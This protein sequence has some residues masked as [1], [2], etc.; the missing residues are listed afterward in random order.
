M[1]NVIQISSA[2]AMAS[3]IAVAAFAVAG[4]AK[5][6]DRIDQVI[7]AKSDELIEVRRDIHRHPEVAG[8]E[9]RTAG[10]IAKRLQSLGLEVRTDVGGHGVIGILKGGKPGPVVAYRADM[11]AL[12]S[13]DPDPVD[14]PSVY[15]GVRHVCGHDM[16]TTV[17]L[18]IA[19]ALSSVREDLGGTVKFI[20][21]PAEETATGAKAMIKDGALIDPVPD[22]IFAV[23]CA[24]LPTGQFGSQV[25]MMLPGLDYVQ[26]ALSGDGDLGAAAEM[27]SAVVNGMNTTGGMAPQAS[28]N[29]EALNAALVPGSFISSGVFSSVAE[30][31]GWSIAGMV[32]ASS[33]A[34]HAHAKQG[35]EEGLLALDLVGVAYKLN[36]TER[37]IPAVNNDADLVRAAE[38]V[39]RKLGGD[40]AVLVLEETTPFFSEDF[41]HFQQDVPGVMFFLGVANEA[42]GTMALPHHPMFVAD[43]AAIAVGVRTMSMVMVDFLSHRP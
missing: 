1:A 38:K 20:F 6:I 28:V 16:H 43:E 7:A 4:P 23:H 9:E 29:D 5:I 19:E 35:I 13:L 33:E 24:P 17:A 31:D 32:R 18:G 39:M 42:E 26:I 21:Q 10:V 8:Q 37:A 2:L 36:Y 14:F 15:P 40:Q 12:A 11:D 30:G 27:C 25:G 41:S 22:A 3:M 34:V